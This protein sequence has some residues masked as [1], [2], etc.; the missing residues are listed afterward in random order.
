VGGCQGGALPDCT[1][2]NQGREHMRFQPST[3]NQ[4]AFS[5]PLGSDRLRDP[6]CCTA[7]LKLANGSLRSHL[8]AL[9]VSSEWDSRFHLRLGASACCP[10]PSG[11]VP[12]EGGGTLEAALPLSTTAGPSSSSSSSS[13]SHP[14]SDSSACMSCHSTGKEGRRHQTRGGR[15]QAQSQPRQA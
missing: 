13:V 12:S 7:R 15:R 6:L 14:S 4:R 3:M 1:A 8:S 9:R 11:A 2:Q 5:T 10:A